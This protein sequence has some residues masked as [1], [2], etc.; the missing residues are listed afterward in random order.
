MIIPSKFNEY[1]ITQN[2]NKVTSPYLRARTPGI[3]LLEVLARTLKGGSLLL[4]LEIGDE[5]SKLQTGVNE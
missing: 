4:L 3:I 5:V 2:I 1:Y